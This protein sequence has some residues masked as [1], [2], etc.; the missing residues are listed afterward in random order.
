M[1]IGDGASASCLTPRKGRRDVATGGAGSPPR[2]RV[3]RG[4]R[5]PA[6]PPR[7]GGGAVPDGSP[8]VPRVPLPLPGQESNT[9]AFHGFRDAQQRRRSTRDYI[10]SPHSG[11][12]RPRNQGQVIACWLTGI[13]P[14]LPRRPR[15]SVA[16]RV[17]GGG[18]ESGEKGEIRRRAP[19]G[20]IELVG[21][22]QA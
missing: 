6:F 19:A 12:K 22:S 14:T 15:E 10:P 16:K 3:T 17:L 8:H 4:V 2:H 21:W 11:R 1:P 9:D 20:A 5:L 13:R 7:R 18:P